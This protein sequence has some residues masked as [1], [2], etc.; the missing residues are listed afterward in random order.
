MRS[1]LACALV[2]LTTA[3]CGRVGFGTATPDDAAIGMDA[4]V[5]PVGGE[6]D[7]TVQP[8]PPPQDSGTDSA[9]SP[10]EDAGGFPVI[11]ANVPPVTDGSECRL[12]PMC[13][14]GGVGAVCTADGDCAQGTCCTTGMNCGGGMCTIDCAKDDDCPADMACEHAVC[15]F[16]CAKDEDC[17]DGQTCEHMGTICEWP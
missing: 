12:D 17:A 10:D 4:E 5:S 16:R 8:P 1:A 7:A 13:D 14:S 3:G 2:L 6:P 11:D 9:V 15:F